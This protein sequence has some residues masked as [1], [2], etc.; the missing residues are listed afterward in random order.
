MPADA[1]AETV[2]VATTSYG[3]YSFFA[4]AETG[5]AFATYCPCSLFSTA[6]AATKARTIVAVTAAT[7]LLHG[8]G[9]L[10]VP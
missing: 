1:V 5:L 2:A 9:I 3:S 6:A 8:D 10:S 7:N 4:A